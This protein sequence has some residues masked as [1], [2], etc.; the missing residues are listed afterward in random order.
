M[1]T[2]YFLL[3]RFSLPRLVLVRGG[4]TGRSLLASCRIR[5]RGPRGTPIILNLSSDMYGN[6]IIP[7]FS[8]SKTAWYFY[9]QKKT[10]VEKQPNILFKTVFD[11]QVS[12]A[13]SMYVEIKIIDLFTVVFSIA[14]LYMASFYL[15]KS[16]SLHASISLTFRENHKSQPDSISEKVGT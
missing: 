8:A 16:E 13:S 4:A 15:R 5:T 10:D 11:L 9:N 3:I 14:P 6:S 12:D 7:I 2:N 1:Y